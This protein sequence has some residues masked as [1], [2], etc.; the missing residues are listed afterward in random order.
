[1]KRKI[2]DEFFAER[3]ARAPSRAKTLRILGRLG[4]N[5]P[6]MPGDE[7]PPGWKDAARKASRKRRAGAVPRT[8]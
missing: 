2:A 7:L 8:A 6:P 1:M 5:N 4:Q 3:A